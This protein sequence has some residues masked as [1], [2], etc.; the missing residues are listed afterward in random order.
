V[1]SKYPTSMIKKH[2]FFLVLVLNISVPSLVFS[3]EST[4]S[5]NV[6]FLLEG[7]IEYGGDE[8]LEVTFT[9]GDTQKVLAGQ[10][11]YVAVGGEF[12]LPSV[13]ALS[14]RA[15]IGYKYNTTAADN[16]DITLTRIPINL[17]P[18]WN[19]NK[20]IRLGIGITTHQFIQFDGD[21]FV[22]DIDFESS[23]GPRIEFAYKFIALTYTQIDYRIPSNA[24][25]SAG[26]FG[27]SVSYVFTK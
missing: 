6:N 26:S 8:I 12:T 24:S 27:V 9:N 1:C 18:Y 10:G 15:S 11:G 3:Q 22:P 13:K 7:G 4:N 17:I 14:L 19:L 5:V 25:V 21:G 20:D 2:I 23:I 16:A